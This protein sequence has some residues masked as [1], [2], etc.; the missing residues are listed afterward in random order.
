MIIQEIEGGWTYK[1]GRITWN[2]TKADGWTAA[3]IEALETMFLQVDQSL[4]DRWM[5]GRDSGYS[6]GHRVGYKR[7]TADAKAERKDGVAE[8]S[9][10]I[11]ALDAENRGSE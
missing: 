11:P 5:E 1:V 8:N 6:E 7:G 9:R 3:L 10:A 2:L 4:R